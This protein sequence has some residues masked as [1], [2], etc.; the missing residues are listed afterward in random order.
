MTIAE[1]CA[2]LSESWLR[3]GP[4][5]V[6]ETLFQ[7]NVAAKRCQAPVKHRFILKSF[8]ILSKAG[9]ATAGQPPLQGIIWDRFKVQPL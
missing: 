4:F 6:M 9:G 3:A 8:K 5:E 1:L 7:R 2:Q